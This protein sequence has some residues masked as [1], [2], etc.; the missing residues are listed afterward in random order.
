M[1]NFSR[2]ALRDQ[3]AQSIHQYFHK[4]GYRYV[5]PP[6]IT[7]SDC[8]GAGEMFRVTTLPWNATAE[9]EAAYYANDFFGRIT[10]NSAP[11]LSTSLVVPWLQVHVP[12]R[13]RNKQFSVTI[14]GSLP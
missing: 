10:G 12:V 6:I 9:D 14:S 5:H 1:P 3:L 11:V 2:S 13:P 4:N 8:E 7:G